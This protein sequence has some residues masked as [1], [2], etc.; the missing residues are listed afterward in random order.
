MR[1]DRN[2]IQYQFIKDK[3]RDDRNTESMNSSRTRLE[4][5]ETQRV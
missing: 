2:T 4:T 1:D 3:I 5:I